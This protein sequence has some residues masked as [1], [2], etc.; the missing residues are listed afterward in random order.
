MWE[1]DTLVTLKKSGK[2]R[3]LSS[4]SRPQ[5]IGPDKASIR[6]TLNVLSSFGGGATY[7]RPDYSS[8]VDILG[9]QSRYVDS[10]ATMHNF[11]ELSNNG[12]TNA[13]CTMC[14]QEW[15]RQVE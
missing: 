6:H 12:L 5:I 11:N 2:W 15:Y 7:I 8:Y 13:W 1:L 10:T 9:S 14:S 4:G 3:N